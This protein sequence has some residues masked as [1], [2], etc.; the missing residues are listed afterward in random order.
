MPKEILWME[1]YFGRKHLFRPSKRKHLFNF[2]NDLFKRSY[3]RKQTSYPKDFY[4]I[5]RFWKLFIVS[6]NFVILDLNSYMIKNWQW[7]TEVNSFSSSS[8]CPTTNWV[9]GD[10]CSIILL[11]WHFF[12]MKEDFW[13]CLYYLSQS[14]SICGWH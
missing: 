6:L 2:R 13:G 12:I 11:Q 4:C 7:K 5:L 14:F 1:E 9:W 10:T 3:F 8:S